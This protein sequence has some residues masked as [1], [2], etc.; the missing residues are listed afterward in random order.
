MIE[1]GGRTRTVPELIVLPF[2]RIRY[3]ER[4]PKMG[5]C[6]TACQK[7]VCSPKPH[8][9]ATRRASLI[10]QVNFKPTT[11]Q[12][13]QRV[14]TGSSWKIRLCLIHRS[15]FTF[16]AQR[17][18]FR[19]LQKERDQKL[20]CSCGAAFGFLLAHQLFSTNHARDQACKYSPYCKSQL[21]FSPACAAASCYFTQNCEPT[22]TCNTASAINSFRRS[23]VEDIRHILITQESRPDLYIY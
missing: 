7:V 15:P 23:P 20:R 16:A 3:I 8:H 19:D 22:S 12:V 2:V 11:I 4:L 21:H 14:D 9:Y 6:R 17:S 10:H 5:S 18:T 13:R 1:L